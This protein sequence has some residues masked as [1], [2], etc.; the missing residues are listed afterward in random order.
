MGLVARRRPSLLAQ[1]PPLGLGHEQEL[2]QQRDIT[3]QRMRRA[4]AVQLR[5]LRQER[6]D[7]LP[8]RNDHGQEE[9]GEAVELER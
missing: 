2:A 6:G 3:Y 1:G 4:A 9:T 7:P 8:E 5:A